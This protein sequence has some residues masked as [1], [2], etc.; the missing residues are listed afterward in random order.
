MATRRNPGAAEA[1]SKLQL[2]FFFFKAAAP[3]VASKNHSHAIYR[4]PTMSRIAKAI[5]QILSKFENLALF[6]TIDDIETLL[7][8]Q[9]VLL[10]FD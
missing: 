9:Q 10:L 8:F 1:T 5:Q 6:V 4:N 2:F 7:P 3:G